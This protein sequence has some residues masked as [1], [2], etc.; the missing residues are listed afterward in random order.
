MSTTKALKPR[1]IRVLDGFP[2]ETCVVVAG[3]T[4]ASPNPA[5]CLGGD[6]LVASI[7]RDTATLAPMMRTRLSTSSVKLIAATRA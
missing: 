3:V 4:W 6:N 7:R 5:V 1:P 2:P